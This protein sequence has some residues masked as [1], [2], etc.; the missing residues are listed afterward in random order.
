V[1]Q[2][3]QEWDESKEREQLRVVRPFFVRFLDKPPH[4]EHRG[5]K[6]HSGDEPKNAHAFLGFS[7]SMLHLGLPSPIRQPQH[8][9]QAGASARADGHEFGRQPSDDPRLGHLG[10]RQ[11]A[12]LGDRSSFSTL[13][14]SP[15]IRPTA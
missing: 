10:P 13:Y 15:R 1:V 7:A 8:R 6:D 12:L 14:A 5:E 9:E 3:D 4:A 11:P 2:T